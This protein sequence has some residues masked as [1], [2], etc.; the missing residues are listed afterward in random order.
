MTEANASETEE[1]NVPFPMAVTLQDITTGLQEIKS[2]RLSGE[3]CG[4]GIDK[5]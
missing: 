5:E 3:V 4:L 1:L 2:L